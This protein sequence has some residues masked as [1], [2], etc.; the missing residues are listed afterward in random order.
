LPENSRILR[1]L[2]EKYF[3]RIFR[4]GRG[5]CPLLRLLRLW[6]PLAKLGTKQ[7]GLRDQQMGEGQEAVGAE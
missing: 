5:T 6:R 1:D 3:L 7:W 2:A 4:G